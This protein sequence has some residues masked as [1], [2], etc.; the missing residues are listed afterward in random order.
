MLCHIVLS[1][2]LYYKIS[3]RSEQEA[4]D[5]NK[6]GMSSNDTNTNVEEAVAKTLVEK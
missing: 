3:S 6:G 1:T 2:I 5:E 4:Q